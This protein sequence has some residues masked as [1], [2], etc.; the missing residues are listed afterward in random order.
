MNNGQSDILV[1]K[2]RSYNVLKRVNALPSMPVIALEVSEIISDP[3]S[4]A[5]DLGRAI[6]KD[7]GLTAKILTV[8]NSPLY[9]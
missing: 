1:K 5:A 4:T 3:R 2:E 8:A 6:S 9:G 7:Q